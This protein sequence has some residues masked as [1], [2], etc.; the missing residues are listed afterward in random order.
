MSDIIAAGQPAY[1]RESDLDLAAQAL[2]ANLKLIEA[3]LESAPQNPVLLLQATQG[4][5]AYA[6]AVAEGQLATAQ[7]GAA[8]DVD[9]H[10]RRTRQLYRRGL[11]YGLR[12]LSREHSDWQQATSLEIAVLHGRLQQLP[13]NAVPALFWTAFCW[14]WGAQYDP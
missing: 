5:A 6:Y 7:H 1:E 12:L 4:F 11:Q 8:G 14:G 13:P 9:V 2:A 10:T 3:L